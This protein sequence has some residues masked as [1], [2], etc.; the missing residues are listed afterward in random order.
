VI[1]DAI[2]SASRDELESLQRE[3]LSRLGLTALNGYGL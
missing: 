3:R 1:L 2:E